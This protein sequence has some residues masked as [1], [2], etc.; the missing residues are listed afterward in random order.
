ME[1]LE[2]RILN[3]GV[4]LG[5]H[6]EKAALASGI[7][8]GERL[9]PTDREWICDPRE[10]DGVT[11]RQNREN[12]GD[13]DALSAKLKRACRFGF[14]QGYLQGLSPTLRAR[15]ARSTGEMVRGRNPRAARV[16][17]DDGW[18]LR[19]ALPNHS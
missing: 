1:F 18:V 4:A 5:R 17:R 12:R 2:A 14:G 8:S 11:D 9:G 6:H 7:E 3:A 16:P 13:F 10:H 15:N 19:G